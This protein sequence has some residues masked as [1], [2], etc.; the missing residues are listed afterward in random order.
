MKYEPRHPPT[1]RRAAGQVS[2]GFLLL[3]ALFCS[4]AAWAQQSPSIASR[5]ATDGAKD[6]PIR[7]LYITGGGFHDFVTQ[8]AIV[9]PGIAARTN[10][11]WTIDHTAGTSTEI[12]IPRHAETRWADE[13][14]VVVYNM[15]FSHVIDAEWIERIA[16]THRDKGVAAVL[17]HGAV[18]SYRRSDTDAWREL[19]GAASYRHDQQREFRVEPL[20]PDHPVMRGLPEGWGPGIDELYEI[21]KLW[22]TVTPLARAWSVESEEYHPVI[23]T[24]TYGKARIFVTTLGH[25]NETMADP[26]YLD[27]VTRGLLWALGRLE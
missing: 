2:I 20:A 17:L 5:V 1:S 8:Q 12:L 14:E 21:E 3:V 6:R 23:W 18:H 11:E 15:S 10:I 25:N 19:T 24:N 9:P 22:P 27:L 7:A 4:P 16:H 13:F 26:V